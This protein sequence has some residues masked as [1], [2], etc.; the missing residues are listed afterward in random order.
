M[1]AGWGG[2]TAG[3]I[4]A[5]IKGEILSGRNDL[6]FKGLSTDSRYLKVGDLFWALKGER[7]DGHD[8]VRQAIEK[9][10]AGVA[11]EKGKGVEPFQA[12]N[13]AV[14]GVRDTL[15]A[16]GDLAG[17]WRHQYG[18]PVA[19]ITGSTGKTTTKEMTAQIF[20]VGAKTLKNQGNF[21]NLIGL[22]LTL[23]SMEDAHRRVVLEMGMNRAGEIG[24]LTEIADPDVG[25][26]TN[27]ARAHLEGLGDIRG[28][29]RAKVELL[30]KISSGSQVILNG[31]DELLLETASSF[32]RSV[33]TFGMKAEN[34]IRALKI[35]NMGPEGFSFELEYHGKVIPIRLG[36]P[37]FQNIY[38]AMASSAIALC[39][40]E[41]PENIIEGLNRF[42]GVK[43]RFMLTRLEGGIML[44]DDTYN[45]NPYSLRVAI[46][47]LRDLTVSGG[48]VIVGLGEMMELGDEAVSAH[49]EAGGMV[50][51][52]G[53]SYFV[54][55][56]DHAEE[57]VK[58]A[59]NKGLPSERTAIVNTHGEMAR[60]LWDV[61]ETGDIVFL[62]G[63]RMAGLEKVAERLKRKS[64]EEG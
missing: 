61:L 33:T 9:G 5:P 15:K 37:G 4:A 52:L 8:Y 42:Q 44:V 46:N 25:L 12:E 26:I 41:P 60:K 18:S 63:S 11:I 39:L 6:I 21:N 45:S 53:V 51:E 20:E 62:K 17:W 16:L 27:V 64:T 3:E 32:N 38:N 59:M 19:A 57:L 35:K 29:A 22:P 49:L 47:S 58:G 31:D 54:A 40:N 34:D 50:A 13:L 1:T 2:I 55:I 43:G 28:V 14:I 10:A 48:R 7:F 24:R 56:G 30:E 36:V 23:L